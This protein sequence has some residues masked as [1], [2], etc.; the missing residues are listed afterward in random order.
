MA[1]LNLSLSL[2][3]SDILGR[4]EAKCPLEPK[5]ITLYQGTQMCQYHALDI[6][7]VLT[8]G[9]SLIL[10]ESLQNLAPIRGTFY[11][12]LETTALGLTFTIGRFISVGDLLHVR[13]KSKLIKQLHLRFSHLT[14]C[15]GCVLRGFGP[16]RLVLLHQLLGYLC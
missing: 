2:E 14:L 7:Q 4:I 13:N 10:I 1:L 6:Q 8:K 9:D 5:L 15:R 12:Q 11:G 16:S 3:G